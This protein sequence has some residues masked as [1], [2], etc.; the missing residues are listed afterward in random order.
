MM[1]KC[2]SFARPIEPKDTINLMSRSGERDGPETMRSASASDD[3]SVVLQYFYIEL[4]KN[5]E[6]VV[7]AELS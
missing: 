2:E 7:V 3:D 6:A 5:S 1:V 4:G